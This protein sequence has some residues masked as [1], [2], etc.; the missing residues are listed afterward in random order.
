MIATASKYITVLIVS[1]LF[2]SGHFAIAANPSM[3]MVASNKI[4]PELIPPEV[5]LPNAGSAIAPGTPQANTAASTAPAQNS[6]TSTQNPYQQ[7][8]QTNNPAVNTPAQS[9]PVDNRPDPIAI[10]ETAKGNITIRLFRKYAPKT[11][12]NF[13][14]LASKGFYNGLTFHRVEPGF[15][16]QGGCPRGDGFGVYYEPNTKQPRMLP[17]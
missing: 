2:F 9:N 10:I 7:T 5:M 17:L 12:A 3:L 13:I 6:T 16:I 15:C 11:T 1:L 4:A 14:D 8:T